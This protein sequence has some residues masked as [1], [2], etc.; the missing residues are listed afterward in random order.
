[1]ST[2]VLNDC[3]RR[4]I[5]IEDK[6]SQIVDK[7]NDEHVRLNRIED[8]ITSTEEMINRIYWR[9]EQHYP[10]DSHD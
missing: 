9:V 4:L 6:L 10:G 1:M 7:V 8:K 3:H 2:D 5:R